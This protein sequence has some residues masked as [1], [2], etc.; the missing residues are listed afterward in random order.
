M[1]PDQIARLTHEKIEEIDSVFGSHKELLEF[2]G[3]EM[4]SKEL[5][6]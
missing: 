5:L 6:R 3:Y 2:F 4:L 1:N